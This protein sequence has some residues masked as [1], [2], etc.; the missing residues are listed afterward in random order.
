MADSLVKVAAKKATHLPPRIDLTMSD[1][2]NANTLMTI[3]KWARRWT[4]S[5]SHKYKEFVAD[6]CKN[7]LKHR[8]FQLKNTTR[9]GL[10]KILQLKSGH[11]MLNSHNSKMNF[12]TS[13]G[14][15]R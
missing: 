2:K 1:L 7:S 15:V 9:R 14:Y 12:E 10:I 5:S 6:I 8:L 3:D 4:N 11:C 13:L